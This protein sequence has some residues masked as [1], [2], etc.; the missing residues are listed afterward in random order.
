MCSKYFIK[1]TLFFKH[2]RRTCPYTIALHFHVLH[3][4]SCIFSAPLRVAAGPQRKGTTA[5]PPPTVARHCLLQAEAERIGSKRK[6]KGRV[7]I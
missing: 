2:T 3:F 6:R 7:F 1:C 5:T 4:T